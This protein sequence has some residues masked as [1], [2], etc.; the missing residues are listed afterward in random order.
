MR[1]C[2]QI[3][4]I[5]FSN[6]TSDIYLRFMYGSDQSEKKKRNLLEKSLQ[7]RVKRSVRWC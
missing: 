4:E 3:V 5:C 7:Q 2:Q 6:I 1:R